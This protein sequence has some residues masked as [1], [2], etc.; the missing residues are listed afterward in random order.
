[1]SSVCSTLFL[2]F[3]LMIRRPPRST[4]FPYT[5]LFRSLAFIPQALE[6]PA[7]PGLDVDDGRELVDRALEIR[8]LAE[9]ELQRIRGV[10]AGE[11]HAVAVED[12]PAVGLNRHDRNAVVLGLGVVIL[13]L[14]DLQV[15]KAPEQ[16]RERGEHDESGD[17]QAQLEVIQVPLGV[18]DLG[19]THES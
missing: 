6:A 17:S 5:T 9:R 15:E 2:F 3:F 12:E 13:V 16:D 10:V 18:P 11:H 14:D 8:D 4:L 1:M 7:V 19:E